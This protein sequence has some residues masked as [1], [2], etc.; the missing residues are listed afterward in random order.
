M[1]R[2]ILI[3]H[4]K[5]DWH[6]PADSDF[7]RPLNGRGNR[8]AVTMGERLAAADKLPDLLVSS[9]AKRARTTARL[10]AG[11]LDYPEQQIRFCPEIYDANLETLTQLLCSMDDKI[12]QLLMVGHNPGFSELGQ[13]L[14]HLAPDW[15]PTCGQL[16]LE[17]PIARWVEAE[18]NCA[19]LLGYDYPKRPN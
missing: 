7:D 18:E 15:L 10:L 6:S 2:L 14:C 17:L 11:E 5:S 1:K 8:A 4:G 3:R 16:E 13:W 9:P 12:E 19:R